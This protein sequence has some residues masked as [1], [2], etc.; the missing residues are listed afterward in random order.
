MNWP[1]S[2]KDE[3]QKVKLQVHLTIAEV[4]NVQKYPTPKSSTPRELPE[5]TAGRSE[6]EHIRQ[7][8][9]YGAV[10]F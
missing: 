8:R 2:I 7:G 5:C 6:A 10:W 1:F 4:V 9:P 3:A